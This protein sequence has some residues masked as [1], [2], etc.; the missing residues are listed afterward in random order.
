M[1]SPPATDTLYKISFYAPPAA[2][3]AI[4]QAMFDAGA[5]R[6]G[7]YDCCAWKTLGSGQYRPTS[8]SQPYHGQ[9]GEVCTTEEYCVEMVCTAPHLAAALAALRD[10][11]PYETPAY[12][13]WP[14]NRA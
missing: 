10:T 14:I 9:I 12:S 6:I 13:Y 8:G 2:T 4:L 1:S 11:H 3:D 5:G 7:N